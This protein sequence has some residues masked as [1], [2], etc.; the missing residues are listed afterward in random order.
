MEEQEIID[1]ANA[2]AN[3]IKNGKI[4]YNQVISTLKGWVTAKY[5]TE[6]QSVRLLEL[7]L[8]QLELH[9]VI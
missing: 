5:L 4:R 7:V 1:R 8:A 9:H 2:F 6:A 3:S